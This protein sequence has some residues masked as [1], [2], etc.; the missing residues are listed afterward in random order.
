MSGSVMTRFV[1]QKLPPRWRF[2]PAKRRVRDWLS[3]LDADVR[4]VEYVGT[5]RRSVEGWISLGFLESRV[6]DGCWRF[7]LRFWGIPEEQGKPV[8]E[9]LSGVVLGV[10]A[11]YICDCLDQQPAETIKPEQLH[12]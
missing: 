3:Q 12:L 7:Y 8:L 1:I 10:I 4:L 11:R 6:V 5:G 9:E 2:V